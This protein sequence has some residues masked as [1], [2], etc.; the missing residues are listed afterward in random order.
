M[1]KTLCWLIVLSLILGTSIA[2]AIEILPKDGTYTSHEVPT[3]P[4][5]TPDPRAVKVGSDRD[6]LVENGEFEDHG[7][8]WVEWNGRAI[9][10]YGCTTAKISYTNPTRSNIGV[11]LSMAI[12]DEDLMK[13]FGTTYRS[14]E[15]Q[16]KLAI[17]GLK[18]IRE[19]INLANASKILT[20]TEYFEGMTAEQ[21][22]ALSPEEIVSHLAEHNFLGMTAEELM[23]L[24]EIDLREFTES[25][26]LEIAQLGDYNPKEYYYVI[27]EDALINPG[28]AIYEIDLYSLPGRL[29]LPKGEYKAIYILNGYMEDKNEMSDF[30]VHL[31]ITLTVQKDLPEELQKEYSLSLATR[32]D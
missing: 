21:V 12:F 4:I 17:T 29:V 30:F 9:S 1:K 32:I 2:S 19:G 3:E 23:A 7:T 10:L 28:Y 11:T 6:E 22:K 20:I 13:Y 5:V 8:V 26:R 18:S 24:D 15:E 14:E 27:G 16:M 25:E 31:P